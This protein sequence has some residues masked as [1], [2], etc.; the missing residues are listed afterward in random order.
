MI[1]FKKFSGIA[2]DKAENEVGVTG[3]QKYR[4]IKM[5]KAQSVTNMSSY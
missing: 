4:W 1:I 2:S 5:S 3:R